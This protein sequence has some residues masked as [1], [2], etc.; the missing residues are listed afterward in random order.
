MKAIYFLLLILSFV[1]DVIAADITVTSDSSSSYILN[2]NDT[3]TINSGVNINSI[4]IPITVNDSIEINNYGNVTCSSSV[5]YCVTGDGS[6]ITINNFGTLDYKAGGASGYAINIE[7]NNTINN[8]GDIFNRR[9][10]SAAIVIGSDSNITNYGNIVSDNSNYA[11]GIVYIVGSSGQTIINEVGGNIITYGQLSAGISNGHSSTSINRGVIRT[12]GEAADGISSQVNGTIIN[13]GSIYTIGRYAYGLDIDEYGNTVTNSGLIQTSGEYAGGIKLDGENANDANQL[14]MS[15]TIITSGNYAD[16]IK[17]EDVGAGHTITVSGSISTAGQT[18]SGINGSISESSIINIE[19]GA[20][21]TTTGLYANGISSGDNATITNAGQITSTGNGVELGLN[22]TLI[23]SGSIATSGTMQHGISVDWN[24][25]NVNNSG[26]VQTSGD[27]SDALRLDMT[28]SHTYYNSGTYLTTGS[29]AHAIHVEGDNNTFSNSGTLK[30]TGTNS[31]AIYAPGENN[32]ITLNNNSN[33][34]GDIY[35]TASTNT[36]K[37]NLGSGQSY[38]YE[39]T[40]NWTIEDLNNRP[41]VTGSAYG[42]GVGN[43]ETQGHEMYQ[44]TYQVNQTL[45][46]RQ[47]ANYKGNAT[48][49][50]INSY[51][52]ESSRLGSANLSSNNL[53]FSNH[54]SGVN[55]GYRVTQYEQP[56]ELLFNYENSSMNHDDFNHQISSDSM[57]GGVLMPNI[58]HIAGGELSV[59]AMVG[60]SDLRGNRQVMTNSSGYSGMRTIGS[61]YQAKHYVV[62]AGWLKAL[63]K[64]EMLQTYVNIGAD[65]NHQHMES[66]REEAYYKFDSRDITQLQ[67]RMTLATDVQP[68]NNQ[69]NINVNLGV[70]NRNMIAGT[71][72]GLSLNNT[73]TGYSH[74]NQSNTY[75]T[76]SLNISYPLTNT[77]L[78]YAGYQYFDSGDDIKMSS[79]QIGVSGSF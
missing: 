55:L 1:T 72:Q 24:G 36:L 50:W 21:I 49:Y 37:I 4:G 38:A 8:Y 31:Y 9:D 65:I 54:R 78:A 44:R 22:N 16:G 35:T 17:I 58:Q 62:G 6:N 75:L 68:F 71:Q 74:M 25:A 18:A 28:S 48:P 23:N 13:A 60:I 39:T 56:I 66:Y 19:S 5:Q 57:M 40:G 20:T 61:D 67:T 63:F 52:N 42:I 59:N 53:Q 30:A 2:V 73:K 69:L 33:I 10:I 47:L 27:N 15:G 70:E 3:L 34:V 51:Y 26:T 76:S 79:G 12:F 11:A 14:S 46:Q 32:V 64:G 43:M 41:M 7:N 77:I 45:Q 29:S